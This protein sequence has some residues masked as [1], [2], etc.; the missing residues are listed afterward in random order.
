MVEGCGILFD[1]E[2]IEISPT[3]RLNRSEVQR[4]FIRIV[5]ES[6]TEGRIEQ[7]YR[8]ISTI[9]SEDLFRQFTV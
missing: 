2:V 9:T 6:K 1:K 8:D 5:N 7:M 3:I 4:E